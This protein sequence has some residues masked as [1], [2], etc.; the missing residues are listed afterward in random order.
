[1]AMPTSELTERNSIRDE[2]L[3]FVTS[4]AAEAMSAKEILSWGLENFSPR[5]AL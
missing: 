4:G 1:M 2:L 3:E 5:I